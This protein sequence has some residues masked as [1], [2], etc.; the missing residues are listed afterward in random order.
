MNLGWLGRGG[1]KRILVEK[2]KE[3]GM[4]KEGTNKERR[5]NGWKKEGRKRWWREN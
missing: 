1:G 3:N 5:W 2:R 4:F